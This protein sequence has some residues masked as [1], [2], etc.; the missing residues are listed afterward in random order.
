M[1]LGIV[2]ILVQGKKDISLKWLRT[3]GYCET[4]LILEAL[5]IVSGMIPGRDK[6]FPLIFTTL[7]IRPKLKPEKQSQIFKNNQ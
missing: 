5:R 1:G 2:E 6:T 7:K 4:I 3:N